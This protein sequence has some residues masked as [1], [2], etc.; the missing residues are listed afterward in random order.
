MVLDQNAFGRSTF[1]RPGVCRS[2]TTHFGMKGR[3]VTLVERQVVAA[4]HRVAE[5]GRVPLQLSHVGAGVRIEQE[6]VVVEPVTLFG[7]VGSVHPKPIELAWFDLGEIAME[8][9]VGVFRHLDAVRLLLARG[10]EQA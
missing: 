5:N 4:L 1:G 2:A 8:H 7:L 3:A 6:F 9:L 10:V